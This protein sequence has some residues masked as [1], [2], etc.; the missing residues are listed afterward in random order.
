[1]PKYK[2][3]QH[4]KL[5]QSVK[6]LRETHC[7]KGCSAWEIPAADVQAAEHEVIVTPKVLVNNIMEQYSNQNLSLCEKSSFLSL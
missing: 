5:S 6:V 1:M 2:R 7:D 4:S 3:L